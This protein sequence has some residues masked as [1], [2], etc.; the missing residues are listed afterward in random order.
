MITRHDTVSAIK[1]FQKVLMPEMVR[2]MVGKL[3]LM[4]ELAG[5]LYTPHTLTGQQINKKRPRV[6]S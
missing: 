6:R 5:L 4:R 1:S 3:V 2:L